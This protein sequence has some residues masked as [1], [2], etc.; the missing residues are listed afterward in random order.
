MSGT[1]R[2]A[3]YDMAYHTRQASIKIK[4]SFKQTKLSHSTE[5]A[6]EQLLLNRINFKT[7]CFSMNVMWTG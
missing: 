7:L 6:N 1:Y 2:A 4:L 3:G 5:P